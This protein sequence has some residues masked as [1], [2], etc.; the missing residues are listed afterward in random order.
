MTKT[1]SAMRAPSAANVSAIPLTGTFGARIDGL[2]L[3]QPLSPA[4]YARIKELLHQFKV[5]VL[6]DQ[7]TVGPRELLAFAGNFGTPE[8]APHAAH[9]DYPGVTGVRVIVSSGVPVEVEKK[10][11]ADVPAVPWDSWHTDG[12]SRGPTQTE[13]TSFLQAV[14]IPEVGRDTLFADMEAAYEGLSPAFQK[15]LLGLRAVHR[16]GAAYARSQAGL[17]SPSSRAPVEHPVILKDPVTGRNALY[18]NRLYT[19]H[20]VGMRPD[21]SETLLNFL[22]LQAHRPEYQLR[23]VWKPKSIVIWQNSRTQHYLVQDMAYRR[24]MHRVMTLEERPEPVV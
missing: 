20:I 21:E 4:Q 22:F 19:T 14:D 13:W 10:Q 16:E 11:I 9:K 12:S 17:K 6:H 2:D 3:G 1:A 5:L 23:V 8:L 7:T 15:F 24:T 18:V